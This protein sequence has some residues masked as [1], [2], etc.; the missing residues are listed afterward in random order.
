M[1]AARVPRSDASKPIRKNSSA[2]FSFFRRDEE[3][4]NRALEFF[5]MGFEARGHI[6]DQGAAGAVVHGA[7]VDTVAVN[8]RADTDVVDV[9][10]EDDKLIL[11]GGI[12]A[13]EFGNDVGGFE[14]LGEDRSV[15][16]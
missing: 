8:G 9:R 15:S 3:K 13:G 5:R 4:E 11:E 2:R 1:V 12:G 16:L 6:H 14:G 10:G 7:V